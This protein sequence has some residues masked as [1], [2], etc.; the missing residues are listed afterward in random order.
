MSDE[1][2]LGAHMRIR[3]AAFLLIVGVAVAPTRSVLATPFSYSEAVSGDLARVPSSA[4]QFDVGDNTISGTTDF[5][6]FSEPD[7][8]FCVDFDSF[9]FTLPTNTRLES[10]SVS[11]AILGN[12]VSKADSE[13][14]LCGGVAD[15]QYCFDNALGFQTVSYL[16]G[17]QFVD[18]GGALPISAGTY[19]VFDNAVG[20][21]PIDA[22]LPMG[23]T[24]DYTWRFKV[25]PVPEPSAYV[26]MLTGLGV[27]MFVSGLRRRA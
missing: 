17:T 25:S 13:L 23:W 14:S 6:F 9:A 24:A 15:Q 12:N 10:I 22:S 26:L 4:F 21:A 5:M 20:I 16:E 27:V 11:S 1:R 7:C 8:H 3:S 18:F 19:T 2:E